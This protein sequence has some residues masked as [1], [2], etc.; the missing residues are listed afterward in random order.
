VASIGD[1]AFAETLAR[2]IASELAAV[3]CTLNFA[4]VLDVNTCPRNP[5]IGDRA[6]GAEPEVCARFGVAWIR[7]LESAGLLAAAKHFPGHGDTSSDSHFELPVVRQ[8]LQR[9]ERVELAP[10]RAAIAAGVGVM[11][12]AHVVYPALDPALPATLSRAICTELRE[13][14]GFHGMLL[15]DDLE[16]RAVADRWSIGEAAVGAVAAGCD[17]LLICHGEAAQETAL[18]A[19]IRECERS[20]AFAARCEQ[21]WSR[22]LTARRRARARPTT[23]SEVMRIVG[24]S[25]SRLAALEIEARL[26]LRP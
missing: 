17:G 2:A 8:S 13:R 20:P 4:P 19:L 10:F 26:G 23:D 6:F 5:V 1:P 12:T 16:M 25:Q 14:L 3:G 9:L 21:A 18:E 15:T 22:V 24:G 11:M 7:G